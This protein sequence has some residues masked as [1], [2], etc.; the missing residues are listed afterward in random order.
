MENGLFADDLV[1]PMSRTL[2]KHREESPGGLYD[3]NGN[4]I[5][6]KSRWEEKES[7][8]PIKDIENAWKKFRGH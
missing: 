2:E 3:E 1:K 7:A 5:T 4:K 8:S 6:G